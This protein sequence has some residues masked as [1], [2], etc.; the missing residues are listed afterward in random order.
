MISVVT[1]TGR[2]NTCKK[3]ILVT[4]WPDNEVPAN[5][6]LAIQPPIKGVDVAI[7]IPIVAAPNARLSH[8]SR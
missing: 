7:F 1:I 6:A 2:M 5:S 8:G 4:V 3:Y